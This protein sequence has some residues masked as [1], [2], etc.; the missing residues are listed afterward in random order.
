V[1]V[2][3]VAASAGD[4]GGTRDGRVQPGA[5]PLQRGSAVVGRV[6]GAL[7]IGL[8]VLLVL[9]VCTQLAGYLALPAQ[10]G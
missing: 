10:L 6:A 7:L 5:R 9:G 2:T 8:G 1:R 4:S 3:A